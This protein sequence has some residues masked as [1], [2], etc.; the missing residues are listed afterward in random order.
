M[1]IV[2]TCCVNLLSLT[3]FHKLLVACSQYFGELH[4]RDEIFMNTS[5]LIF[6][7]SGALPNILHYITL[8]YIT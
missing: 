2:V 4:R 6:F 8:H 7:N 1:L 5:D 3:R